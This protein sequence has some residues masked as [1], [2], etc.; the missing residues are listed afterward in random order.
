MRC[1]QECILPHSEH[2]SPN[3]KSYAL[4]LRNRDLSPRKVSYKD[5][6]QQNLDGVLEKKTTRNALKIEYP[7]PDINLI[8][9]A[10]DQNIREFIDR[11]SLLQF[12]SIEYI[13][14]NQ[15][16]DVSDLDVAIREKAELAASTKTI[17]SFNN[18]N[19]LNIEP[20]AEQIQIAGDANTE[21]ILS[22]KDKAGD[23]LRGN[24]EDF[25]FLSTV[26][27]LS[28]SLSIASVTLYDKLIRYVEAGIIKVQ[29]ILRSSSFLDEW[30]AEKGKRLTRR[31]EVIPEEREDRNQNDSS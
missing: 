8:P 11:F 24:N 16:W 7:L 14:P 22:G 26:P 18:K 30:Y 15:D 9:I 23:K 12:A 1:A 17:L 21:I 28:P 5:R 6:V 3:F 2:R 25:K 29:G 4:K 13:L 10:S 27:E 19:G 31:E 20:I